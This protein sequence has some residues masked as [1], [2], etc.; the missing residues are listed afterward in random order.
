MS[1]RA[2][3]SATSRG[4]APRLS[5]ALRGTAAALGSA[6]VL[7]VASTVPALARPAA[8]QEAVAIVGAEIHTVSG[9]VIQG[10]TLIIENGRISALGADITE[11]DLPAPARV[12]DGSNMVVTPGLIDSYTQ[13]G[14]IE[15]GGQAPGTVDHTTSDDDFGAVFN[16]LWGVNPANTLIPVNRIRGV[17]AAVVRPG[18]NALFTG[19]GALIALDGETVDAMT[20]AESV[21]V[22]TAMG[23]SGAGR[24][25]GSRAANYMMLRNALWDARAEHLNGA[26][27]GE[28][29][30]DEED[31]AERGADADPDDP[32]RGGRSDVRGANLD[33]LVRVV[34][35]ELPLVVQADRA[36]DLLLALRL[37]DEFDVRLVVLGAREGWRVADEL[38]AAGVPV[39]VNPLVN[40]PD[41]EGL[42]STYTNAGRMQAAGVDV[43]ISSFSSHSVRSLLHAAG[44]AVSY[45]MDHAAALRAVT[46]APATVWGVADETGS[47]EV[48]RRADVVVWT[49]DPFELSTSAAHVF[50]GGRE[51]PRD[52]RQDR[53]FQRYR[54]LPG[55]R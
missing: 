42:S 23:E 13:I 10:G 49:G 1:P 26:D 39:I 54:T 9:D 16:P 18:G 7:A 12:I 21:A 14:L 4:H 48:G 3:G 24:A 29:E 46:L 11:A 32:T 41:F 6:A 31:A 27:D 51:I 33:V 22:Y 5:G 44:Q 43:L 45:G 28:E 15:I 19:Q 25:G 55:G 2:N 35:G 50:I 17:T 52:S 36:S 20:L 40:L 47:L 30:E 8:A 34:R 53:L 38:A 37:A